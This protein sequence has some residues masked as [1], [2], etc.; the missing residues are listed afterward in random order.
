M[1]NS[2]YL[3]AVT[4]LFWGGCQSLSQTH[5]P[6]FEP[7]TIQKISTNGIETVTISDSRSEWPEFQ[8]SKAAPL[9]VN[10]KDLRVAVIGDTGCRLKET[11][12]K[13]SY[14]NCSLSKEWPFPEITKTLQSETYDF[15]VHTGDYH[16]RE[17]CT[18]AKLCPVY[19]TH[20]GYGWAAWWDDF[21]APSLVL[22]KKSPWLFVRGNHED[23]LRAYQ[24][25]TI[26]SP[27]VKKIKDTCEEIEDYQWVEMD[28][29]IFINFDNSSF[30][31]RKEMTAE[32]IVKW[33][34]QFFKIASQIKN[35]PVKKEIW[36]LT[37][38]PVLGFA[39]NPADAEPVGI[40]PNMLRLIKE[41]GLYDSVDIFLS[42]HIHNQQVVPMNEKIQL[43]VGHG[44]SA[45][46]PFGRKIMTD[47]LT[48]TTENKY[49]F[50]YAL[51]HRT[52]YKKWDFVF[53]NQ[54]GVAQLECHLAKN[55]INCD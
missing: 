21:F 55:K 48:T 22:F 38:K 31:D 5:A 25:W 47:S 41:T 36:F 16:Y 44:G 51:F 15:A 10:S 17:H 35:L 28:D 37:H 39:P 6:T 4:L 24:G 11:G 52:A 27:V 40:K 3:I 30:E 1:K 32:E 2:T 13:V 14:Q 12:G 34:A 19:A 8:H 20:I 33:K 45:L 50:G 29:L 54:Y 18:D 49:S 9:L 53:K 43:I 23:C 7:F 46:D 26:L 42:G